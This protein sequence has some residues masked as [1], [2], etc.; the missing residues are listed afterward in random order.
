M[1]LPD[2][3]KA[4]MFALGMTAFELM[5]GDELDKEDT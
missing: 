1:P 3:T 5:K 2:L 4:D